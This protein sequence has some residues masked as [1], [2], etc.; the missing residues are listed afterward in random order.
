MI[1]FVKWP[2]EIIMF[3]R[4]L[5]GHFLRSTNQWASFMR[6]LNP[7]SKDFFHFKSLIFFFLFSLLCTIRYHDF[8]FDLKLVTKGLRSWFNRAFNKF[9]CRKYLFRQSNW[10][11]LYNF[12]SWQ[13]KIY[14]TSGILKFYDFEGDSRKWRWKTETC[15]IS[16]GSDQSA[17]SDILTISPP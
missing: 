1:L 11:K 12:G 17:L 9:R 5:L 6:Q 16:D 2:S 10:A 14:W 3:P 13:I 7:I 4:S 15:L 8:A